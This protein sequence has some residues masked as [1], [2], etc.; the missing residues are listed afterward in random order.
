LRH[1]DAGTSLFLERLPFF[2]ILP[3]WTWGEEMGGSSR[4]AE[5]EE[6]QEEGWSIASTFY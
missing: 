4:E 1:E 5:R 6:K 2:K 3:S